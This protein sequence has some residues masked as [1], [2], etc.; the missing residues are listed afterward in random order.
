MTPATLTD[1]QRR[2]KGWT[3]AEA[4]QP[5]GART[6]GGTK[7][8]GSPCRSFLNLSASGF[9]LMHD[10]ERAGQR[11][12]MRSAGGA[13]AKVARS[14]G[15]AADPATVPPRMK[16]LAD[17]VSVASWIVDAVLRGDVD[18]RTA[19]SATKAVRQFQLGEEKATLLREIKK[20]RAELA[21]ATKQPRAA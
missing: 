7:A 20:L 21:A 18:A 16:S 13:A 12:A 6:C 14:R 4:N 17:A 19:E 1:E 10:P 11:A 15:R 3:F 8:N 5:Q 9:C 2:E